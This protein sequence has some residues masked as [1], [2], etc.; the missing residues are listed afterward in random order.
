MQSTY[1]TFENFKRKT[2]KV[3]WFFALSFFILYY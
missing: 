3:K 2:K 1:K